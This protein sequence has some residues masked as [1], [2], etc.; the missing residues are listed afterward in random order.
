MIEHVKNLGQTITTK[1]LLMRTPQEAHKLTAN[2][3]GKPDGF[4]IDK[5][6]FQ[7]SIPLNYIFAF[8]YDYRKV[9]VNSKHELTFVR[10]AND[11]DLVVCDAAGLKFKITLTKVELK[12]PHISLSDYSRLTLMKTISKG[13]FLPIYYRAVEYIENPNLPQSAR[14]HWAI[15]TTSKFETARF[16]VFGFQTDRKNNALKE[17]DQLDNVNLS[18]FKLYL[19]NHFYPSESLNLN[20]KENRYSTLYDMYLRFQSFFNERKTAYPIL[21]YNTFGANYPLICIDCSRQDEVNTSSNGVDI[22]VEFTCRENLPAKTGIH[23]LI[24]YETAYEY[25]PLK[26]ETRKKY[27]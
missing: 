14:H 5:K 9:I 21:D 10:N 1:S 16:I 25:C 22:K 19:N 8:L 7:S 15:K 12:I 27:F 20:F 4:V 18:D 24:F 23:C 26:S 11:K 13:T 17:T 3:F 2:G 6:T